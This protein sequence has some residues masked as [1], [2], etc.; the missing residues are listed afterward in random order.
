MEIESEL[1]ES[2]CGGAENTVLL[3]LDRKEDPLTPLLHQWTYQAM[4]HELIGISLNRVD[5]KKD[6]K[7]KTSSESS[8]LVLSVDLDPFYSAN[9]YSGYGELAGNMKML[10]DNLQLK[11]KDHRSID[12]IEDMQKVLDH[13]PDYKKESANVYKH[14]DIM[15]TINSE[16]ETR[17][18]L[19]L[20]KLEQDMAVSDS[21][22]EFFKVP[23]ISSLHRKLEIS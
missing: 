8:E 11:A 12:T 9:I 18:L 22:D 16:V 17:K 7:V 20:S 3:I 1:F 2:N 10:V 15:A 23:K 19:D 13:Y 6:S 21:K 5:I 4:A 14:V